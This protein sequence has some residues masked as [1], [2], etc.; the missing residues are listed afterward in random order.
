MLILIVKIERLNIL[1]LQF[2]SITQNKHSILWLIII[3]FDQLKIFNSYLLSRQQ[4][5]KQIDIKFQK[6]P[7]ILKLP[8]LFPIRLVHKTVGD[9]LSYEFEAHIYYLNYLNFLFLNLVYK[10]IFCLIEFHKYCMK[11][12]LVLLFQ[13][14]M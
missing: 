2:V 13:Q 9:F 6:N 12:T 10:Q 5:I 8:N 14:K 3:S 4:L 7:Q 1:L 11:L